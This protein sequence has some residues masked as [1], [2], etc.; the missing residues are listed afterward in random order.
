MGSRSRSIRLRIYFL[1]AIPLVTMIGMLGYVVA[2]TVDNAINM[3]RAPDLIS[4]TAVPAAKFI[5]LLQDERRAAVVYLS[6]PTAANGQQYGAAIT[7]TNNGEAAFRQA[8]SSSATFGS[9]DGTEARQI[10]DLMGD[11]SQLGSIRSAVQRRQV[12]LW[13]RSPRTVTP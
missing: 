6:V 9:E 13:R 4:A 1:V 3:D 8:M 11:L 7:A 10:S 12:T 5:N 2:T